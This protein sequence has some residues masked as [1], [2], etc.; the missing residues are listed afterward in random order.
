[1]W[2]KFQA[3][4]PEPLAGL[5]T[6]EN[7]K[8][9]IARGSLWVGAGSGADQALRLVR[10]MILTRL[11][12]PEAFGWMAI[13]LAVSTFFE[14][15]TDVGIDT[16]IVQSPR[17]D[18]HTYLNGAFWISVG[19]ALGLYAL[20]FVIAPWVSQ[21]YHQASLGALMRV[22]FL[23][24]LF[25]GA[26]SPRTYVAHKKMDFKRLVIINQG[27][28]VCGIATTVLLAFTMRDVWAL[29]IG[30]TVEP[31]V[32]CAL[33]YLF[34]PF[35]PGFALDK[36]SLRELYTF[37][38]GVFGLPILTF[39]FM[40]ADIF[41]IGK[42]CSASDLGI[43]SMVAALGQIPFSLVGTLMGQI[44]NPAFAEIQNDS[45]RLNKALL[46][47][48]SSLGFLTFTPI[49]Y[50]VLYGKD[51][52]QVVY[53]G[54]Y[55]KAAVPFALL[56]SIAILRMLS[57]PVISLY[58]MIGRP[59]LNRWFTL[60]RT[61]LMILLV[62]PA[63]KWYGLTGAAGA[64]LIAMIL[65]YALQVFRLR[66]VTGLDIRQYKRI[67]WNAFPI[68]LSVAIVWAATHGILKLAPMT[69]MAIGGLACLLGYVIALFLR[70]R[71]AGYQF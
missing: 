41:V 10:N 3:M 61:V 69:Q 25:R 48:T 68:S 50:V 71:V 52:L 65:G 51:M 21:F 43:Y 44:A 30:F 12:V 34:C 66:T 33:S 28:G 29:V 45:A 11:L 17:I 27:S 49:L 8:A 57:V 2:S 60:L 31:A 20:I 14:S 5:L 4:L 42:L 39:I 40:R 70:P 67:L 16:A 37:S 46:K 13:I 59:E 63:T 19:R 18:Q 22:A 56:F 58:Y 64:G 47:V 23:G 55:A 62:Y 36:E 6:G 53:G 35:R 38:R 15:F 24:T 32:R 7:L 1:M 26:I 54:A 9:R